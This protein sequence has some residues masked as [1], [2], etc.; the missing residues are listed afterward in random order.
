MEII[1]FILQYLNKPI[2]LIEHV[3]DRAAH[4]TSYYLY[5]SHYISNKIYTFDLANTIDWYVSVG[6]KS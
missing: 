3:T 1:Q 4:D 2:D 5:S 6:F